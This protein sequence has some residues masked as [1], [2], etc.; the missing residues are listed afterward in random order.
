MKVKSPNL[1][2][3]VVENVQRAEE[4]DEVIDVTEDLINYHDKLST[5][6]IISYKCSW[7]I[8][9][10]IKESLLTYK[11]RGCDWFIKTTTFTL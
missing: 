11:S 8:L 5:V 1:Q 2:N 10:V 4:H 3:F 9:G 6:S 7:R